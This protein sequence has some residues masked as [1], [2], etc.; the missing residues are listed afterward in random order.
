[1]RKYS[2]LHRAKGS[3]SVSCHLNRGVEFVHGIRKAPGSVAIMSRER[4]SAGGWG[5]RKPWTAFAAAL[6]GGGSGPGGSIKQFEVCCKWYKTE[7]GGGAT[8]IPKGSS[9]VTWTLNGV[10]GQ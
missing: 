3:D 2:V 1:M 4:D 7:E 8:R 10:G 5:L 6:S 9:T